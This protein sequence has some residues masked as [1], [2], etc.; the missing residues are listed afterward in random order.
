MT[1]KEKQSTRERW[2]SNPILKALCESELEPLLAEINRLEAEVERQRQ[3]LQKALK[4][5]YRA[6]P[7]QG[8]PDEVEE[9]CRG[10]DEFLQESGR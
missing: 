6:M 8:D 10:R 3:R 2:N 7:W 9:W 5:I 1:P 4:L